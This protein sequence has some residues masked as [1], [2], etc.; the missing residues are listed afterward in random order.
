[1]R[2][3]KETFIRPFPISIDTTND[4]R[5][6]DPEISAQ[7]DK[8]RKELNLNNKI[9]AIGVDR[10]D[11]TKGIVERLMA[12][13]RFLE[14][15]PEYRNRF[16]F[17]QLGAPSRTHIKRYHELI[18]E[19]DELVDKINWKYQEESWKPI[20]YLK[21]HFSHAEIEPFYAL[22]DL[23]VVSSLHDGMNLVAKE[24][25]FAKKDFSGV[26]LLSQFTGASKELTDAIL[27]NPYSIKEFAENIKLAIELPD[28][29]KKKRMQNMHSIIAENNVYRWAANIITELINLK[30]SE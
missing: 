8:L 13:D 26:L 23:G 7:V 29:E 20:V 19:I 1:M 11:Y 12:V 16:V 18:S 28:M 15:Y 10:I 9:V 14:L 4:T 6:Y 2:F 21:K 17:I 5:Y 3:G 22:S 25:V 27:I 24:Y 30:K